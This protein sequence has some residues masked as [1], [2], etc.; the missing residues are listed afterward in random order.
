MIADEGT[1]DIGLNVD[2][3]NVTQREVQPEWDLRQ[4]VSSHNSHDDH[5]EHATSGAVSR[6]GSLIPE[7]SGAANP[8]V[9]MPSYLV[10]E[11]HLRHL[12]HSST[13][14]FTQKV[15]QMVESSPY[16]SGLTGRTTMA[17]EANT[18]SL[19]PELPFIVTQDDMS[20]LPP[21]NLALYYVHSVKFRT[22]TLFHLFDEDMFTKNLRLFYKKPLPFAQT[23][24]LW[25]VHFLVVM[26]LGKALVTKS[27]LS[28]TPGDSVPGSRLFARAIRL[29][30]DVTFIAMEPVESS[31]TLCAVALYLQA[32]D[33]RNAAYLTVKEPCPQPMSSTDTLYRLAKLYVC[34]KVMV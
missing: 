29:L 31:E 1:A 8:L 5:R 23:K 22:G 2:A 28:A 18:Y 20:E 21:L 33:H 12:G 16:V 24:P 4:S 17:V 26:A 32:I 3:D 13:W 25:L 11:G 6:E 7:P 19:A 9:G 30:P 34:R 27:S 14:S 15:L 10:I